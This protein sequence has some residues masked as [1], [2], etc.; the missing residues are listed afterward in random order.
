MKPERWKQIEDFYQAVLEQEPDRRMAFLHSACREDRDL[1]REVESLLASHGQSQGPETATVVTVPPPVPTLVGQQL[2][3]C[4]VLSLLGKGGMGEVYLARDTQLDRTVALKVLPPE[5]ALDPDRLQRFIRE[6]KAASALKHPNIAVI[7]EIGEASGIH[8][9]VME[10]VE[11]GTLET[12]IRDHEL[13][14]AEML[15]IGIQIA[16]ALEEAHRQGITHRDIKP[17]NIMLTPRGQVK[18]L[19][20]GLAK[21]ARPETPGGGTATLTASQTTPGVIMGTLGY[22]APEQLLGQPA[23]GRSDLWALGVVL[24]EMAAGQRPFQGQT[25]F[26]LSAAILNQPPRPLPTQ[27]PTELKALIERCLEKGPDRRY[28]QAGEA[29]AAL[30]AIRQG[31][32]AP[33]VAW[34]YRL[35]RR[36]WLSL[37]TTLV[38]LLLIAGGLSLDWFQ[39][40]FW[41]GMPRIQSLAVLPLENLSGDKEQEYFA[42]GMTEELI[43]NL[44]K[45]GAL[46]VISRTSTMQYKGTKK[47]AA[48]IA[49]ELNVD[50]LIEGSVLREGG[51][52]RIMPKLILASTGQIMWA[53]SYQREMRGVLA[54][55]GEIA[56]AIAD[57]VRATLT[58]TEHTR[59]ASARP[60][61]PEAYDAYLKGW[62]MDKA[63]P[64]DYDM[65]LRYYELALKKD[66]NYALAYAGI[67][68]LWA[69]SGKVGYTAAREAGLKAK[70]AALKALELDNTLAQ[71]HSAL[72]LVNYFYEWDWAGAE[73][74]FKRAIEL[75]PN[76]PDTRALYSFYLIN[77]KRPEEGMAE[78]QR[79]LELDPLNGWFQAV[80]GDDL[81]YAGR[82]DEALVQYRK[83]LG[84]YS[85]YP[86]AH[87]NISQILFRKAKYEESLAEMKAF[88]AEDHEVEEALTQ[89]YA[90]A[91]YRGAMRRLADLLAARF[92]KT[93]V[94]P[95]YVATMYMMAGDK[96]QALAWLEKGLEVHD[97]DASQ[98]GHDPIYQT[99][100]SEPRFQEIVRRLNLP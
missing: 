65:A 14:L 63:T 38:I 5:F 47:P 100:R 31:T 1:L 96:A 23:D 52:V 53:D 18:V 79:A 49:K 6:A 77:M 37:V 39:R 90:Q 97:P 28:Q 25:G 13:S 93:Y 71:A 12:R 35:A 64:Q 98:Y 75:N 73:V 30:E 83:V 44:A 3:H 91:G 48:Q 67:A 81:M 9:I 88:Y 76:Y 94:S 66:P 2:G 68:G 87:G 55:Q 42:D 72:A 32:V 69:G 80:H 51:Q 62:H 56:S 74:E 40:R 11:G 27:V 60:V 46:K 85:G 99:L 45:I 17:A 50:G 54:L 20:F 33:W 22:M 16:D 43:T 36:P 8:F 34:R 15:D 61:N 86:G 82:D 4:Q 59:L 84:M 89:G 92:G 19:D 58:S 21:R 95:D 10:Y 24:Y 70:A 26:D 7:H 29:R 41:G 78:I 57:K